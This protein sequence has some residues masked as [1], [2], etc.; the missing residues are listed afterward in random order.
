MTIICLSALTSCIYAKRWHDKG[1]GHIPVA[2]NISGDLFRRSGVLIKSVRDILSETK[3]PPS[4]LELELTES[5]AMLDPAVAIAVLNDLEADGVTC[6][7]DDFGTG[8]SSL[9]VLK[10]FPLKK[11]KID[12]SF[13][14]DL[15]IDQSDTAIV[16]ATIAVGKALNLSIL[17]EGVETKYHFDILRQMGCDAVQGYL[18]SCPVSAE[19]MEEML[20]NWDAKK[21]LADLK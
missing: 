6:S 21:V 10:T 5:A 16:K 12:R 20:K 7:I 3:L 19:E 2:V 9:S 14:M 15:N 1:Y 13:V 18:F 11:L 17:A 4:L 8:Y